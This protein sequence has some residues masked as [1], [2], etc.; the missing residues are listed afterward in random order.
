MQYILQQKETSLL[1][2]MLK[3]HVQHPVRNDWFSG[4]N[5]I[6]KEWDINLNFDEITHMKRNVF[7]GITKKKAEEAAFNQLIKKKN[8]GSKGR[9]ITFS[10]G[11]EMSDYLCPNNLLCVEEQRLLFQIRSQ[12]N[13]LP[14]NKGDPQPCLTGCGGILDNPHIVR[15]PIINKE[16]IGNYNLLLNGTLIEKKRMLKHWEDSLQKTNS[17]DSTDSML[18]C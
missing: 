3:A 8:T 5:Q 14:A 1:C 10:T 12:T 6:M 16:A 7:K 13:D 18:H 2:K 9:H 17:I 15:C 4:V 11:F